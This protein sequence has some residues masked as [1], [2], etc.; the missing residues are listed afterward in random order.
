MNTEVIAMLEEL[1]DS[2]KGNNYKGE[3]WEK[4]RIDDVIVKLSVFPVVE[5]RE[6]C[7]IWPL[8]R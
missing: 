7:W 5:E 6:K 3:T 2:I 4:Q 1:S 8:R